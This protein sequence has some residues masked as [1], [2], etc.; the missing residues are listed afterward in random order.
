MQIIE[1]PSEH[2]NEIFLTEFITR[3]VCYRY[4]ARSDWVRA[5]S[6]Q[7]IIHAYGVSLNIYLQHAS[8]IIHFHWKL[9]K[10]RQANVLYMLLNL[11]VVIVPGGLSAR[12]ETRR[13]K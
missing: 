7:C 2:N 6:E 12:D 8:V 13:K 10:L 1:F 4:G 11:V 9:I 5:R 3:P